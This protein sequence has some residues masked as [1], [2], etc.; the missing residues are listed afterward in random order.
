MKKGLSLFL[1][2]SGIILFLYPTLSE[3]CID[4]QQEKLIGEWEKIDV[5]EAEAAKE[6]FSKEDVNESLEKLNEVFSMNGESQ[7]AEAS[8]IDQTDTDTAG[9]AGKNNQ[10]SSSI[11]GTNTEQDGVLGVIE[12]DKIHV[13]LP[14]L[15]GASARNLDLASG[16]LSG[17][18]LPG[19]AGNSAIAAHRSRTYGR[20]FNRLDEIGAGDIVTVKDKKGTYKYQV[21]DT[22]VVEPKDVSV[23]NS[24]QDE[25]TLTLITCTPI[26]TATHRLIVKAKMVP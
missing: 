16:L 3:L 20:M 17:T 6:A 8:E 9:N 10:E 12:I 7:V 18:S 26:D 4:Y 13:R 5:V 19:M 23:L 21:Y 1:I 25:K 2:F 11:K 24:S 22:L 14:I 15:Y